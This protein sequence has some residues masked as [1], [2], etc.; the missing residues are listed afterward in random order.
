MAYKRRLKIG[1]QKKEETK[2]NEDS[3]KL[4]E[5]SLKKNLDYV[6]SKM[7]NS[8]D[9]VIRE[10]EI[11]RNI[12][13]A[14]IYT[15]GLADSK[16]INH[17]LLGPILLEFADDIAYE[18]QNM[19]ELIKSKVLTVGEI[20]DVDHFGE[21][22][23]ALLSGD[24]LLLL[25]GYR[26]G[27]IISLKGWENRSV[28]EASTETIIRGPKESFIEN[29]RTNTAMIRRKVRNP[30]LWLESR[31][32]GKLSKTNVALMYIKGIVNEKTVEEVRKRL[33]RINIDG[34][35][36]S[37]YI[38]QLVQDATRTPFPTMY[39]TER[40]DVVAADLMEGRIA[41]LVD[42]TPFVLIVPAV[43]IQFFQAAE[44]YYYRVEFSSLLRILRLICFFIALMGPSFYIAIT[45]F[46][47]EMIPGELLISLVAQR[48][49]V[50]FPAFVEALIMEVTFEILREAGI[51]MPRAIGQAVSIVGTLV[52]GTA[53]V[54]AGMVSAAMV[55]VVSITAISNF[56]FPAINMAIPIR[57]LRF[58]LMALAASFGLLGIL[59]GL[60]VLMLHLCGLRSFGVP[61]MSPMAPLVMEDI[62]DTLVRLPRWA[63]KTRPHF[64]GENN[65][66]RERT[67]EPRPPEKDQ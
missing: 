14:V 11:Q 19:V 64:V 60:L 57:I 56:V 54:D 53:A 40:P 59:V 39:N 42:G 22:F 44:D 37:G 51:R 3:I 67:S 46:H 20:K 61:Y 45:T 48:E 18:R 12:K 55:I 38:E 2:D 7:G 6:R 9:I 32:I 35:L 23:D 50:P 34:I 31:K 62:K 25:D 17:F 4:L 58:P 36:E 65:S 26:Q 15:D 5:A 63:M 52:V 27:I 30:N 21:L 49:S 13:A 24:V 43:F 29:L 66:V 47:Q 33:D 16:S 1:S 28:T 10:V 8:D 41:I